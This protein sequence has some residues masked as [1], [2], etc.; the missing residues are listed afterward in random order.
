M[1]GFPERLARVR[2]NIAQAA[3]RCGRS[4]DKITLVAARR[5]ETPA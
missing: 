1:T 5:I 3:A 2:E 4:P